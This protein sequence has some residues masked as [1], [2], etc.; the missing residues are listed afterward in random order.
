MLD[1]YLRYRFDL[2]IISGRNRKINNYFFEVGKFTL[3][4]SGPFL[5]WVLRITPTSEWWDKYSGSRDYELKVR[6]KKELITLH[7]KVERPPIVL[8][9]K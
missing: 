1:S 2:E 6:T 7:S 5:R 3:A 4:L 9:V 8:R